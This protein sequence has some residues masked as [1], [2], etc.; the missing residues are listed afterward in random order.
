MVRLVRLE[1]YDDSVAYLTVR[2]LC[3]L[4]K[5]YPFTDPASRI[6]K[7]SPQALKALARF[8]EQLGEYLVMDYSGL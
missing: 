6:K 4:A 3:H 1:C 7:P 5:R 8:Q 2:A